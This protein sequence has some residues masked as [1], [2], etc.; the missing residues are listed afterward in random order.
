MNE[1]FEMIEKFIS[2]K[3]EALAFSYDLP[4]YLIEHYDNMLAENKNVTDLLNENFPDIC[5]EYERGQD[6]SGFIE[7]VRKEYEYIKAKR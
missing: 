5:A 6:P 4:D 1:V 7:N 3:Y 2:G